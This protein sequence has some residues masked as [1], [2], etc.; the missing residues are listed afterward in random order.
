M[1]SFANRTFDEIQLGETVTRAHRL[2]RPEL[3]TLSYLTGDVDLFQAD[4]PAVTAAGQTIQAIAAEVILAA[5]L[6]RD[7]PGP[8]TRVLVKQLRYA[9]AVAVGDEITGT[10]SAR[11]KREA[12]F[13]IDF[14]CQVSRNGDPL[15]TGTI[16]VAAPTERIEYHNLVT[17][18]IVLRHNDAFSRLLQRC[19]GMPPVVCAIVHPC[20]HDSLCGPIEAAKLGL[21]APV[22]VG[23][24]ARIRAVAE[25]A[26][27]D[28]TPYRIVATEHSHAAADQAVAMAR[29]GEVQ[30]LMKGSLHTDELMAAVVASATGL[31]TSRRISHVFVL[32][33]PAY[34]RLL[35]ITDAAINVAP[36][37][38]A[39]ADI[40][41]NAID[42]AH[43]LGIPEPRLA[44]L[45]A[46]ETVNPAMQATI[47]AAMLCKM[48]ERGQ[49]TG[50]LLDGPLAFDN[51]VSVEAARTKQLHSPVAG[52]ADILLAPDLEAGNMMAK[53]LQYLAGAD[54]AGIVL[55]ARVPIVLTSRSDSVRSRLAS[56]IVMA[57]LADARRRAAEAAP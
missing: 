56:T 2:T 24:P 21:I 25:A 54:S 20:D 43:V 41:Q 29:A 9:G 32:D 40:A 23:P 13:E 45:A 39:K 48:A 33:V 55:G 11:A 51:A 47:D 5:L 35:L 31:R 28:L 36:D 6:H 16:T 50:G 38:A 22:L 14:D 26:G 57:L 49:I 4:A 42:L 37:A 27:V 18:E 8:G 52:R 44:I 10:V 19:Q 1:S 17:P 3:Q 30:A 15:I 34:P 53:Q 12:G 46:V 7:L